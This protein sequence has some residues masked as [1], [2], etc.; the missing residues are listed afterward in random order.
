MPGGSEPLANEYVGAGDP[1]AATAS[2]Y[3]T[4]LVPRLLTVESVYEGAAVTETV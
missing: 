3:A 2:E 4:F 1:V